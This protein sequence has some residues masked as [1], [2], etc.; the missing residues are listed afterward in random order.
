[1]KPIRDAT[2]LLIRDCE[3]IIYSR[4][5][6]DGMNMHMS[7][8]GKTTSSNILYVITQV[9]CVNC[10]AAKAVVYEALDGFG[11]PIEE[12]DLT[13]MD[14]DFEFKLLESQ[15]FIASTPSIIYS[16]NGSL[17]LLYN[18]KIPTVDEL[19]Q[20]LGVA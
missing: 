8:G 4:S 9:N 7:P 2:S 19:R 6:E 11:V 3:P 10:P 13:Q 14:P 16:S 15:I 5:C 18:G 17:K 1:M 20:V 12:V